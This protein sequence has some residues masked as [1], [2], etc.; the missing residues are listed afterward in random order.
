MALVVQLAGGKG[1]A[2]GSCD[3]GVSGGGATSHSSMCR[4]VV[5]LPSLEQRA[6]RRTE[7]GTASEAM[8]S[9]RISVAKQSRGKT[10]RTEYLG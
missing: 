9:Y 2:F 10:T 8:Q 4:S 3:G 6:A 5:S 7:S 1:G